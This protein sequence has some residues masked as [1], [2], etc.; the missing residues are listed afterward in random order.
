MR[1]PWS[2]P[3]CCQHLIGKCRS[4]AWCGKNLQRFCNPRTAD[5]LSPYHDSQF[6]AFSTEVFIRS[7]PGHNHSSSPF[8]TLADITERKVASIGAGQPNYWPNT[9]FG[10][11]AYNAKFRVPNLYIR[12]VQ[13]LLPYCGAISSPWRIWNV[14]KSIDAANKQIKIKRSKKRKPQKLGHEPL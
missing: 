11:N 6:L 12:S 10:A 7:R 9:W 5:R 13:T 14:Q 1:S 2:K 4:F 3:G 8:T